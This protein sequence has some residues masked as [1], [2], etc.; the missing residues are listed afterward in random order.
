MLAR[1]RRSG[2]A[3]TGRP[4]VVVSDA[5]AP[6]RRIDPPSAFIGKW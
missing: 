3:D 1:G 2:L 6:G 5:A 4:A